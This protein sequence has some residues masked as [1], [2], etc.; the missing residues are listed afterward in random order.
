M[1]G[2][3]GLP[4]TLPFKLIIFIGRC[5]AGADVIHDGL[6]YHNEIKPFLDCLLI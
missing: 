1:Q 5:E 4:I 3:R 2:G 6:F